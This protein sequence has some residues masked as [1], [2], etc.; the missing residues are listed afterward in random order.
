[1]DKY[2]SSGRKDVLSSSTSSVVK[3][4]LLSPEMKEY[5]HEVQPTVKEESSPVS[6]TPPKEI[7]TE[8]EPNIHVEMKPELMDCGNAS[9]TDLFED[10]D[11]NDLGNLIEQVSCFLV[12]TLN[13][14]L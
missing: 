10:F 7:K 14:F 9:G 13:Y 11:T 4:E 3:T 2:C 8:I 6:C 5:K 12:K 1:M